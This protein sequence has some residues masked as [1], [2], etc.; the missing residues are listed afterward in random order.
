MNNFHSTTTEHRKG[1]HLSFGSGVLFPGEDDPF[2][3]FGTEPEPF[4]C[5]IFNNYQYFCLIVNM[6]YN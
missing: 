6:S 3:L 5:Y 2:G 4:L 1:Q